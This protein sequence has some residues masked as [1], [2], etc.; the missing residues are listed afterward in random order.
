MGN[1]AASPK[2]RGLA[3]PRNPGGARLRAK[4]AELGHSLRVSAIIPTK[5][6][7]AEL[8][9]TVES[10]LR[11]TVPAGELVVVDQS[12]TDASARAIEGLFASAPPDVSARVHLSYVSDPEI[13]GLAQARNRGM[14]AAQGDVCLFLDDDVVLEPNFL[15]ELIAAYRV[16]PDA[17]GISGVITNYRRPPLLFRLWTTVFCRG[18]FRDDRQPLYWRANQLRARE[19]QQVTR[20]GGGLMSFRAAAVRGVRFDENLTGVCDG[21]DVDFC[22]QLGSGADFFVAP[23]ARLEH[24]RSHIGRAHDHWLRRFA[25]PAYYLFYRHGSTR[26]TSRLCFGWLRGGLALA[27]TLACL[28]QRSSE[29]WYALVEGCDIGR[30]LARSPLRG[31]AV[32]EGSA[33]QISS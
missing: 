9:A 32:A 33:G 14:E 28:R 30:R 19:P 21:E 24:K 31:R 2:K 5:H 20:L 26:A 12:E 6:R 7:P 22:M 17:V 13:T 23:K 8:C 4:D 29:P 10:L 18:L 27:A 1:Y 11:Q 15:E 16:K 25:Q 3:N